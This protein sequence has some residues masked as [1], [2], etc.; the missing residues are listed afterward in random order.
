MFLEVNKK[1]KI[2]RNDSLRKVF[3]P[4]CSTILLSLYLVILYSFLNVVKNDDNFLCLVEEN[5]VNLLVVR[6]VS[7][8]HFGASRSL[9]VWVVY[10]CVCV[11][12]QFV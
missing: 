9:S 7:N 2:T 11:R 1:T 12:E 3:L 8:S 4:F 5:V 10:V 6:L